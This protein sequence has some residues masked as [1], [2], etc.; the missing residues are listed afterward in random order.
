MQ[1][2]EAGP[3]AQRPG[4]QEKSPEEPGEN[5]A[6]CQPPTPT[7]PTVWVQIWAR[8]VLERG[9]RGDR[10]PKA[11]PSR[12]SPSQLTLASPSLRRFKFSPEKQWPG[13]KAWRGLGS[14]GERG[15]KPSLCVPTDKGR[16]Q[17]ESED[18]M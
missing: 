13:T 18:S 10:G 15:Q 17:S 2:R 4:R 3:A 14:V 6:G 12:P 7:P 11:N 16:K 1:G 9:T 5:Y 8:S